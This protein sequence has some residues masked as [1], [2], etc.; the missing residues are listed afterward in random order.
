MSFSDL[1]CLALIPQVHVGPHLH[2]LQVLYIKSKNGL[3]KDRD[4]YH[5]GLPQDGH[6]RSVEERACSCDALLG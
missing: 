3:K 1:S 2:I 5:E 4:F 6:G